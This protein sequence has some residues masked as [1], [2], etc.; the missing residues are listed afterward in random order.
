MVTVVTSTQKKNWPAAH[1]NQGGT[2]GLRLLL[3]Q[4]HHERTELYPLLGRE[5]RCILRTL[6]LLTVVIDN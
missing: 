2:A 1:T 6:T 5:A 3:P 4:E